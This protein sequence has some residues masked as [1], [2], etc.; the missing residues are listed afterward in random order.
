M[1]GA[2]FMDGG[3]DAAREFVLRS[4]SDSFGEFTAIPN[5]SN[6]KGELQEMLQ[7]RS[8]EAPRY[9]VTGAR[10]PDHDRSF[11]CAVFHEGRELG[12]G[13]G[14]SKRA[15]QSEAA[16]AALLTLKSVQTAPRR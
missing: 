9:E 3:F 10:G 1:V 16:L 6:P 2:I 13:R 7:A 14:K 15:A 8:S 11:E 4:F 12:R 5:L